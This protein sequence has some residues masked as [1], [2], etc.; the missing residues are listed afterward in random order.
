MR[1][2][3]FDVPDA[4]HRP[5]PPIRPV[6]P[7]PGTGGC[8]PLALTAVLPALALWAALCWGLWALGLIHL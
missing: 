8:P 4:R 1:R 6:R 5:P 7:S 3:S 2:Q